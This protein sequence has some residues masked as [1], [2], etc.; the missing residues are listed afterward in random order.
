MFR[1]RRRSRSNSAVSREF[2]FSDRFRLT[3]HL[4]RTVTVQ[5]EW[6]DHFF[7]STEEYLHSLI[8]LVNELV[9]PSLCVILPRRTESCHRTV[10][11][12]REP[13]HVGRL[14]RARSLFT[15]SCLASRDLLAG[16]LLTRDIALRDPDCRFAKE[17]S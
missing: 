2:R 15:V 5:E 8:S 17:L 1:P 11:A 3:D 14:W 12:S 10:P 4:S 7:L 9:R 16:H 13:R 6:K